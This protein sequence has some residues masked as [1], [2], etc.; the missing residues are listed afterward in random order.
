[1]DELAFTT[2]RK[3][4]STIVREIAAIDRDLAFWVRMELNNGKNYQQVLDK[5]RAAFAVVE[6]ARAGKEG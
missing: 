6:T 2:G 1:M 5:M 3:A 4:A